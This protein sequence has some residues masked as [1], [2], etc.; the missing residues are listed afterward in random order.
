MFWGIN[1]VLLNLKFWNL[2][3][4]KVSHIDGE[5]QRWIYSVQIHPP[6]AP[7][8]CTSIVGVRI[9]QSAASIDCHSETTFTNYV[10]CTCKMIPYGRAEE[11]ETF[12]R[13]IRPPFAR[14][15]V[16]FHVWYIYPFVTSLLIY[17]IESALQGDTSRWFKPP[18]DIK[19][20]VLI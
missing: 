3:T 4:R 12:W 16:K 20:Q 7:T 2:C 19:T 15:V 6:C 14:Q 10:V 18:V 1:I 11:G 5:V 8:N 17:Q 13:I 9:W